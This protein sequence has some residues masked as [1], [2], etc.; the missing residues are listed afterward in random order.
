[1]T[2]PFHPLLGREFQLVT[3]RKKWGEDRVYFYDDNERLSTIPTQWTTFA[4]VDPF[5]EISC[6]RSAFR[7]GDLVEL[8]DLLACINGDEP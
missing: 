5:V 2:H 3:L 6:G 4:M 1:V 7:F 8:A